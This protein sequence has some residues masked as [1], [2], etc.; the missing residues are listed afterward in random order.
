MNVLRF[1][2]NIYMN[3]KEILSFSVFLDEN[4]TIPT[5]FEEEPPVE[6][7]YNGFGRK[8]LNFT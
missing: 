8:L 2:Q 7:H 5:S 3:M 4:E 6:H 1:R